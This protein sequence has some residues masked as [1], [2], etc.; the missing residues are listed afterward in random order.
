MI[1]IR[2][3]IDYLADEFKKAEGIDLKK[4]PMALQRLK[5]AC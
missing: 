1:L 2:E 3:L 5:E 4:D